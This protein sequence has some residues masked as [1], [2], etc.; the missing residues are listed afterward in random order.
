[1]HHPDL[2]LEAFT[3]ALRWIGAEREALNLCTMTCE[4]AVSWWARSH[5]SEN[6]RIET[7]A[8][9]QNTLL[10]TAQQDITGLTLRIPLPQGIDPAAQAQLQ[11]FL[12]D[13]R[14]PHTL[15]W[16]TR[17]EGSEKQPPAVQVVFNVAAQTLSALR[18]QF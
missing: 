6:L 15:I 5:A 14:L 16:P 11:V 7:P 3:E 1:M 10:L 2:H 17:P 4:E 13:E 9:G 8:N 18:V 12:G